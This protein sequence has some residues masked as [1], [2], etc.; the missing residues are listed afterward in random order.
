M[1]K[2]LHGFLTLLA[3]GGLTSARAEAVVIDEIMYHPAISQP[4]YIVLYNQTATPLDIA[5]WR[6]TSGVSF[7]FPEFSTNAPRATFLTGFERIVL[8]SAAESVTR[9]TY[10]VPGNV[11]VFG[12]WTG[13]LNNSGERIT[14]QDK[15]GATLCTL[16]YSSANRWPAG[17]NGTGHSLVLRDPNHPADDGRNWTVSA[18]A[19]PKPGAPHLLPPPSPLHQSEVSNQPGR[20]TN[21]VINEIMFD[22]PSHLDIGE[23]VELFNRGN[24]EVDLSGWR[25][26]DGIAFRFPPETKLAPAGYLVVAH[27]A[28]RMREVYG[29]IP[30]VGNFTG[31]LDNAGEHL[32]L[33]DARGNLVNEVDYR[34]GGDWPELTKGGGSSL[35]LINPWTDN[36]LPSAWRDSD[37]SSKGQTTFFSKT[38]TYLQAK[39][40]GEP[41]DYQEL[42]LHLVGNGHM[43]LENLALLGHG[44]NLLLR[45]DRWSTN[46][47]GDSGWLAQGNHWASYLT[48]GEL[49]LI[50]EG[51]GDNRPNHVELDVPGL[52]AGE[53]YAWQFGARWI[54]GKPRLIAQ[55]WDHSLGGSFLVP[56]PP[57]LGTP[58]ARN[59]RF[60]TAPPP[61]LDQLAHA[62]PVPRSTNRVLVTVRV[63]AAAPP[64]SVQLW[65]RADTALHSAPWSQKA[66]SD[67][68]SHGDAVA[69]D[70]IFS[71]ELDEYR[72]Q[73]QVVQFF[74]RAAAENGAAVTLPA[75]GEEQPA[76]FVVDDRT[77][78]RDLR[79]ARI[80]VSAR[81]LRAMEE[82]NTA[83]EE[84]HFPRLSNHYFNMT[85]ISDEQEIRYGA[86]VRSS[87]SPLTRTTDLQRVKFKLPRDQPFRG[88]TKFNY[89][90]DAA[91]G[92]AYHNRVTRYLLYLLGEPAGENEFVRLVINAGEPRLRE[93]TEMVRGEFLERHFAQGNKGELYRIDD[94]WWFADDG[95]GMNYDA[96]WSYRG[97]EASRYRTSWLK[98]SRETEDDFTHLIGLCRVMSG[99]NSSETEIDQLL[100]PVATLKLAAVRG[101]IGDWDNF[102]MQR[103][104]N[105]YFYRRPG[106]GRFQLLHWDSDEAFIIGQPLYGERIRSWIEQPRHKR[107]FHAFVAELIRLTAREPLRFQTWLDLERA[108]TGSAVVQANYPAFFRERTPEV[109]A[110]LGG[111]VTFRV[112]AKQSAPLPVRKLEISLGGFA[113]PDVAVVRVEDQPDRPLE[114]VGDHEWKLRGVRLQPG[115]NRLVVQGLGPAGR[116]VHQETVTITRTNASKWGGGGTRRWPARPDVLCCSFFCDE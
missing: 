95:E 28:R 59:S 63:T 94:D 50:A 86:K 77:L 39:I 31:K 74:V 79:N 58:G 61:Q 88:R 3:L 82:G 66:L 114:W 27:D 102:T 35:E 48:N 89:D 51:H 42:Q 100:D 11:R 110:A 69:G 18:G 65:H 4:E 38:N 108:S 45:A 64:G 52:Q 1:K 34:S 112:F 21:V 46:G 75:G 40:V 106:D 70:G 47:T 55:S 78:P 115:D 20:E 93:D 23:Y 85:F 111:D 2:A 44:T 8:S 14:L 49:H 81:D 13:H 92:K 96:D 10:E 33:V 16:K 104:R 109:L 5:E 25:F 41:S 15:N 7:R 9:A 98:R 107:L 56:I 22:P 72:T 68:G 105:G 60:A 91:A 103:G 87:G 26:T 62:P 116:V 36:R 54:S 30:V 97:E 43:V 53:T 83:Q 37:E 71:A 57:N 24:S 80:I 32:R 84:F 67:D 6:L 17:A 12:P 99:T 113:P 76:L 90:D 29:P 101:F 73:G 19:H